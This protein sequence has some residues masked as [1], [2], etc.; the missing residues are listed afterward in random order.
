MPLRAAG[1]DPDGTGPVVPRSGN[2][3]PVP[4]PA[5]QQTPGAARPPAGPG[6]RGRE[7]P[8]FEAGREPFDGFRRAE[9]PPADEPTGGG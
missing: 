4:P 1:T 9:R 6:P 2:A 3:P 5:P 8:D 7:I